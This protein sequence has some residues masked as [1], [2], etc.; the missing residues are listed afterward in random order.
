MLACCYS[1]SSE[2]IVFAIAVGRIGL[3][4]GVSGSAEV[5]QLGG[6]RAGFPTDWTV[7]WPKTTAG[8]FSECSEKTKKQL[9]VECGGGGPREECGGGESAVR[10]AVGKSRISDC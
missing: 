2:K 10:V 7:I 9:S 4:F 1:G 3:G 8:C 6:N 5:E